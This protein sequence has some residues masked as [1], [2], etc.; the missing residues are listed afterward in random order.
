M[1]LDRVAARWLPV[2]LSVW[3]ACAGCGA[4]RAQSA[5]V[6]PVPAAS[7]SAPAAPLRCLLP[8]Q[9]AALLRP[10]ANPDGFPSARCVERARSLLAQMSLEEKLGQMFQAERGTVRAGDI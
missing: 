4:R 5:A 6:Q 10:A 1:V 2:T 8:E 9:P 3:L 7:A